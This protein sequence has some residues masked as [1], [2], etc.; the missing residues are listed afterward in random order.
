MAACTAVEGKGM[1][2]VQEKDELFSEV[3]KGI[4]LLIIR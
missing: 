3:K 1:W 4:K 2:E